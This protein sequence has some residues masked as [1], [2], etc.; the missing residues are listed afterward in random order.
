MDVTGYTKSKLKDLIGDKRLSQQSMESY[1]D[2]ATTSRVL[3]DCSLIGTGDTGV[4]GQVRR[5][6][7]VCVCERACLL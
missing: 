3:S 5:S 6:V 7:C 4:E 2:T 1:V